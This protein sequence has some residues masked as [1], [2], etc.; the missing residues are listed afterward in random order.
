MFQPVEELSKERPQPKIFNPYIIG[1][2][3]GQFAIHIA[4]LIYISQYVQRT[5]PKKRDVDL[6]GEFEPSLLNSAIYLLQLIQ[7]IS[8]FAINYQG[9]P[10]RESIKE[11]RGMYYG[12]VLVAGVAFSCAT[13][14][15]PEINEQLKLVPFTTDFKINLTAVMIL[16]YAGCYIIEKSL[17]YMFSDF[18][19]KD[20]AIRRPDQLAREE[21]RKME[22]LEARENERILALETQA[23]KAK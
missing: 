16:D 14:F 22:E 2:V 17:K 18:R 11:N 4:T 19:P 15:V 21:K 9:R 8:T 13:E 23:G 3:L 20:I 5:E 12:I 1:S 10:F 6:E 7:Q